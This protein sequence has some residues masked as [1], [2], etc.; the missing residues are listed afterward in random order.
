MYTL[1]LDLAERQ[2]L[3]VLWKLGLGEGWP[4]WAVLR[5]LLMLWHFQPRSALPGLNTLIFV[6]LPLSALRSL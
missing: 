5:T 4:G 1:M 2:G 3:C 6:S